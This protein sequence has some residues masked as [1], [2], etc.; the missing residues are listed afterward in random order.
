MEWLPIDRYEEQKYLELRRYSDLSEVIR[1]TFNPIEIID[2]P[3][4]NPQWEEWHRYPTPLVIY[5]QDYEILLK[6]YF[7]KMYPT[8]DA[9]DGT[10]EPCFDICFYNWLGESDWQ[11]VISEIEKDLNSMPADRK[12]FYTAFL[13]WLKEALRHTTIIVV[14]GNQ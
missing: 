11:I 14:E 5:K 4:W 6:D 2:D 13:D 12:Q 3:D 9:F 8:K 7:S 1:L 10:P